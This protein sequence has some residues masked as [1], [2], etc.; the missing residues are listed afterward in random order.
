M[1]S[2]WLQATQGQGNQWTYIVK[3]KVCADV[4]RN[5]VN[6]AKNANWLIEWLPEHGDIAFIASSDEVKDTSV[7]AKDLTAEAK[8][9]QKSSRGQCPRGL[10]H[11][12]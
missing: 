11:C 6:L 1:S 10:H 3:P 4:L 8:D 2:Q 9:C 12:C 7:K 5:Y